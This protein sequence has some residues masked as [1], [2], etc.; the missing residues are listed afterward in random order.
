MK[1]DTYVPLSS[2]W[3]HLFIFLWGLDTTSYMNTPGFILPPLL[4]HDQ[5]GICII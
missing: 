2:V 1:P 4:P 3:V 5:S